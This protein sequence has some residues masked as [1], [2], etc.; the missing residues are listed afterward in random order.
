MVFPGSSHNLRVRQE[1]IAQKDM[2]QAH[3]HMITLVDVHGP[4]VQQKEGPG[5]GHVLH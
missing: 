2:G 5:Q 1:N 3:I 4:V